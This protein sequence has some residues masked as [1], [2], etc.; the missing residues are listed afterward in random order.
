MSGTSTNLLKIWELQEIPDKVAV[1]LNNLCGRIKAEIEAIA[2][3]K[4]NSVLN[5]SKIKNV[6]E[7]LM[8]RDLGFDADNIREILNDNR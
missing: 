8:N 2:R 3:A 5:T 4:S 7:E 1:A 6:Y